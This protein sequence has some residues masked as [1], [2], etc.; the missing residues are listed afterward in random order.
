[1]HPSSSLNLNIETLMQNC[2]FSPDSKGSG[3]YGDVLVYLEVFVPLK[4]ITIR[5]HKKVCKEFTKNR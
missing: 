2:R 4:Q 3:R 1:M 5:K